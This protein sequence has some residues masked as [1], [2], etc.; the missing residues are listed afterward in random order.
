MTSSKQVKHKRSTLRDTSSKLTF[1]KL[2]PKVCVSA[3]PSCLPVQRSR[4][5]PVSLL[6][7]H[8]PSWESCCCAFSYT[9]PALGAFHPLQAPLGSARRATLHGRSPQQGPAAPALHVGSSVIPV[10]PSRS[11][12]ITPHASIALPA[13]AFANYMNT[14]CSITCKTIEVPVMLPHFS[15]FVLE[16]RKPH[17]GSSL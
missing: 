7:F 1:K 3:L 15:S 8:F 16:L 14:N 13:L 6:A 10:T 17:H 5:R 2:S 4:G 11:P 9:G 12:L